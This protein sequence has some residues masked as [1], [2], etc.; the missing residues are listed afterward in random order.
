M[1]YVLKPSS[2]VEPF[3]KLKQYQLVSLELTLSEQLIEPV[4]LERFPTH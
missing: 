2:Y 1:G 3:F 4:A